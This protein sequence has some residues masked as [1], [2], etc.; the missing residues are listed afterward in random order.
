M[1]AAVAPEQVAQSVAG[2]QALAKLRIEGLSKRYGQVEALRRTSLDVRQGE[3]L[4]LLGPSGS[5][6]T[7]LLS[8]IAGLTEPDEGRIALAVWLPASGLQADALQRLAS[9]PVYRTLLLRL[10]AGARRTSF[11]W[12]A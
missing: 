10:A 4:T 6:K 12:T 8:L 11:P 3:F 2:E 7:T 1:T 9:V 5:G